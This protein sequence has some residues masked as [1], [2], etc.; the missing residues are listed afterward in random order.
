LETLFRLRDLPIADDQHQ[1]YL[2]STPFDVFI[3]LAGYIYEFE[4]SHS[5]LMHKKE[6]LYANYKKRAINY[7]NDD[8]KEEPASTRRAVC[9][10]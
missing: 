10:V 2:Q 3:T 1:N 7:D 6:Q 4:W 9:D 5:I 8:T